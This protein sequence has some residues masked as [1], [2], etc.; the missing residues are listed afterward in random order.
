MVEA[1][2]VVTTPPGMNVKNI[3]DPRG[4]GRRPAG[5]PGPV[6]RERRLRHPRRRR[7]RGHDHRPA[8]HP[9]DRP[10]RRRLPGHARG[11]RRPPASAGRACTGPAPRPR[12][13]G[14]ERI[15]VHRRRRVGAAHRRGRGGCCTSTGPRSTARRRPPRSC[16]RIR[17]EFAPDGIT[18]RPLPVAADPRP[19]G[20]LRWSG[21]DVVLGRWSRRR[22]RR[23]TLRPETLCVRVRP[24]RRPRRR[25]RPARPAHRCRGGG[26]GRRRGRSPPTRS[27]PRS[28]CGPPASGRRRSA[29]TSPS[30]R[31]CSA[32]SPCG[33]DVLPPRDGRRRAGRPDP[34]HRRHPVRRGAAPLLRPD[35]VQPGLAGAAARGQPVPR[36]P[37]RL[38]RHGLGDPQVAAAGGPADL[39]GRRARRERP[40]RHPDRLRAHR[41]ARRRTSSGPASTR[42]APPPRSASSSTAC[43]RSCRPAARCTTWAP[44]AWGRPT[45]APASATRTRGCGACPASCWPATASSRPPTR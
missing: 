4:A 19:D 28:C 25:R 38:R 13:T 6:D 37:G 32:W 41:R 9:P 27:A 16:E 21:T 35:D 10:R 17:D 26:P 18:V 20:S 34:G 2:P 24:R 7:R 39:R 23:F 14:P 12:P 15:A 43:R 30:T 22:R 1:G 11:G 3:P 31:C 44:S 40:A 29:G 42:P 36:Q 8:G 5:L 33:A 45:T